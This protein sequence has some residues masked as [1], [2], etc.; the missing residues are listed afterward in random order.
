MDDRLAC[1]LKP[2]VNSMDIL[3][4]GLLAA[5]LWL[6]LGAGAGAEKL[7]S[8]GERSG[9]PIATPEARQLGDEIKR[10]ARRQR[11]LSRA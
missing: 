11:A 3:L 6:G 4:V 8:L 9:S 5:V 7:P 2:R 10:E 1:A